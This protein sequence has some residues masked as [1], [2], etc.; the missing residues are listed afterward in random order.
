MVHDDAIILEKNVVCPP[1]NWSNRP[2]LTIP[3]KIVSQWFLVLLKLMSRFCVCVCIFY[4]LPYHIADTYLRIYVWFAIF[5]GNCQIRV[6][7]DVAFRRKICGL[8]YLRDNILPVIFGT[9]T[10]LWIMA[11][12]SFQ[13]SK[14]S[15]SHVISYTCILF[16][17]LCIFLSL[18][19]SVYVVILTRSPFFLSSPFFSF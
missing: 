5:F 4:L 18:L 1:R 15:V 3:K 9:S 17:I 6:F 7:R 14:F 8:L 16:N 19:N 11:G 12:N 13:A 2:F 10:C